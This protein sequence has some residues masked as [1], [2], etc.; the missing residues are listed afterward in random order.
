M[1]GTT[2][3]STI[4]EIKEAVPDFLVWAGDHLKNL[5]ALFIGALCCGFSIVQTINMVSRAA[6]AG[7]FMGMDESLR[8]A[9]IVSA[10]VIGIKIMR[11][12]DYT[13]R[14]FRRW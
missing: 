11:V 6:H 4:E 5:A 13:D 7:G 14:L 12:S 10:F 9:F 2:Q 8:I 1:N 3:Q